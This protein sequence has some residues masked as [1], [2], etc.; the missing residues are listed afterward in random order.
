MYIRQREKGGRIL[1]KEW[2]NLKKIKWQKLKLDLELSILLIA[3]LGIGT[4]FIFSASSVMALDKY[5]DAKYFFNRQLFYLSLGAMVAIV[6]SKIRYQSLRGYIPLLNIMTIVLM[7]MTFIPAFNVSVNGATR[8]ISLF[9]LTFQPSELAKFTLILTL[10]DL[11]DRNLRKGVFNDIKQ[12][13]IPMISY[14]GILASIVLMQKHLSAT[15][16]LIFISLCMIISGGLKKLY[17]AVI[18]GAI[19]GVGIIGVIIEPFRIKRMFSFLDPYQDALGTGFHIIQS[20]HAL[21]SGGF[22]GLG[23]GMSRQKFGPWLPENHTDFILAIIGEE[24][25]FFGVMVVFTLFLLLMLKGLSVAL[26]APDFYGSIV[27]IGITSMLF[28][29]VAINISVVSGM[30][31]VTGMV[32]PFVSY[33]GTSTVML[34]MSIGVLLNIASQKKKEKTIAS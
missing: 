14:V 21:G 7:V 11:I 1:N 13:I 22:W 16:V 34:M 8:W 9:G 12:G 17:I 27:A 31:P 18:S 25:G 32:L 20:W 23:L 30:F 19:V 6:V 28:F 10:G 29:Q 15:G 5:G 3:L 33:G 24:F 2:F 26:Q 4:S